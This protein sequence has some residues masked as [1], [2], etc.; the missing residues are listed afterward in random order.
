MTLT[1]VQL[2]PMVV[3]ANA[4]TRDTAATVTLTTSSQMIC[5]VAVVEVHQHTLILDLLVKTLT[6]EQQTHNI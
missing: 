3:D 2:A 6:M 4:S 1:Q 5:V